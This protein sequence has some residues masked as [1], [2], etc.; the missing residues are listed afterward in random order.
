MRHRFMSTEVFFVAAVEGR[1]PFDFFPG[2][3]KVEG[4]CDITSFQ[5]TVVEKYA[6]FLH[7]VAATVYQVSLQRIPFLADTDKLIAA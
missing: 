1:V 6:Q 4:Q 5:S 3:V 2:T 7:T